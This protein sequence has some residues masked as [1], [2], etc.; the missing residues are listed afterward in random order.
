MLTVRYNISFSPHVLFAGLMNEVTDTLVP[1]QE[2]GST[3]TT[4]YALP[5]LGV[6]FPL[7]CRDGRL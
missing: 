3:I 4:H 5:G 1:P 6:M 7:A 2:A